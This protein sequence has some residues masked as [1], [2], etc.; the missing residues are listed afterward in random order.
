MPSSSPLCPAIA[1]TSLSVCLLSW[2]NSAIA[3]SAESPSVDSSPTSAL[4]KASPRE[5]IEDA[6]ERLLNPD[7]SSPD[8]LDP[9]AP[10]L[11][12][13]DLE[14]IDFDAYRLGPGDSFFVNVEGFPEASFQATLDLEGNILIPFVGIRS[15][16]GLNLD[17]VKATLQVEMNRFFVN[18]VVDVTLVARRPVRVTLLG[19]VLRPGFYPLNDP[20]LTNALLSSGGVTRLANLSTIQIRRTVSDRNGNPIRTLEEN[21]DLFTPLANGQL[22]PNIRL[23]DGDVVI[24]PA[25][26]EDEAAQ[27]DRTLI[28]QSNLAQA[29]MT[30]RVVSYPSRIGNLTL[31]SGSTFVDAITT[32]SPPHEEA[33]IRK[34]G[35]I[36]FDPVYAQ[37]TTSELDA[38]DALLG[39]MS[40]NI[41]LEDNDVLVI[42]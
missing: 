20:V 35:L 39:N 27:Y 25:L 14:Q 21:V 15:F 32:L 26:T 38:K 33:N 3:W 8:P 7:S 6:R 37:V 17:E 42:S 34:I 4:T 2:A 24:V 19:E 22:L 9:N 18:P 30:I 16:Q 23:E 31:P 40:E 41:V 28:A 11:F 10:S 1:I 12:R 5:L 36:R 13:P 29:T